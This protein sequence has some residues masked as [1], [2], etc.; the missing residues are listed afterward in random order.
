MLQWLRV[1]SDLD[2]DELNQEF[3]TGIS[4]R[5]DSRP[6]AGHTNAELLIKLTLNGLKI[7]LAALYLAARKLPQPTVALVSGA[8]A[9]EDS[10]LAFDDGC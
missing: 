8:L 1:A 6:N 4:H 2:G 5:E 9:D 7:A 3:G 10:V